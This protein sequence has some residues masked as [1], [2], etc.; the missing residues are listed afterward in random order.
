MSWPIAD[1]LWS[2]QRESSEVINPNASSQRPAFPPDLARLY[3]SQSTDEDR[4]QAPRS[5]DCTWSAPASISPKALP[6]I[7]KAVDE[8]DDPHPAGTQRAPS[9]YCNLHLRA[10]GP[11]LPS[12][13]WFPSTAVAAPVLPLREGNWKKKQKEKVGIS[14]SIFK[15]LTHKL[16]SLRGKSISSDYFGAPHGHFPKCPRWQT[17]IIPVAFSHSTSCL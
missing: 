16:N 15:F 11:G 1:A 2:P 4:A 14:P 10:S 12:T 6:A 8:E 13:G 7:H 5:R 3:T 9:P 17:Q